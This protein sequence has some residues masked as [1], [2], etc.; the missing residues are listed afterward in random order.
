MAS[1]IIPIIILVAVFVVIALLL[2][3]GKD[4]SDE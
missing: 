4:D 2:L 3:T 1:Y